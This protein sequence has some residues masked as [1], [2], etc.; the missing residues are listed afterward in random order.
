MDRVPLL[1]SPV[2]RPC[3]ASSLLR[4]KALTQRSRT[5][6]ENRDG[7]LQS[8]PALP[9]LP[10]I[11]CQASDTPCQHDLAAHSSASRRGPAAFSQPAVLR[12]PAPEV[13]L[14]A[15]REAAFALC[16]TATSNYPRSIP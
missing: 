10:V 16:A 7:P 8:S 3:T 14:A 2:P 4:E 13:P 5:L 6:T 11:S 9:V 1:Q 15:G 12:G